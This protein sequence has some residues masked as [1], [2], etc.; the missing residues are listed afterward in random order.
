MRLSIEEQES[1]YEY[2]GVDL[3]TTMSSPLPGREDNNPSFS[4]KIY[5]DNLKWSDFGAGYI[6]QSCYDFIMKME[7]CDF[8]EALSKVKVILSL[9]EKVSPEVCKQATGHNKARSTKE[10]E[11]IPSTEWKKWE[12]SYWQERGI[13]VEQLTES[14]TFPLRILKIDRK[15]KSTSIKDN[16]KFIYYLDKFMGNSFKVYSPYDPLF[17]WISQGL[18]LVDYENAPQNRYNNLMILSGR[19]DKL[20][21]DNYNLPFD[22]TSPMSESNFTGIIR[23]L[24]KDFKHYKNIYSLLDFDD[25]GQEFSQKLYHQSG[26]KIKPIN[27]GILLNYL[28]YIDVKD[29]DNLKTFGDKELEKIILNE[30]KIQTEE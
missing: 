17:K 18:D 13:S 29:I 5:G 30:I 15:F 12:I 28:H 7:N 19:K 22:T 11:V 26:F 4:T 2:Y 21:F 23:Q 14:L 3:Y 24:D 9:H 16:P 1:V 8:K 27:F 10:I 20:V 25:K 6:G